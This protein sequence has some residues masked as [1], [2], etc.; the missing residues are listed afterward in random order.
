M[1][2]FIGMKTGGKV[3]H[4]QKFRQENEV[5]T[6]PFSAAPEEGQLNNTTTVLMG[7]ESTWSGILSKDGDSVTPP[8]YYYS[9][10]HQCGIDCET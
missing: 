5:A 7:Y 10:H 2:I 9:R 6:S 8:A 3:G 1:L 4:N